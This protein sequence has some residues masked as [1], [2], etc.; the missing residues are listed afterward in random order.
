MYKDVLKNR[1]LSLHNFNV[2]AQEFFLNLK[3]KGR[4]TFT[5]YIGNSLTLH[6]LFNNDKKTFLIMP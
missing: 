2:L 3:G 6:N 4:L 5:E 1:H